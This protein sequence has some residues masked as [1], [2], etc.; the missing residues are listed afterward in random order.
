MQSRLDC[1]SASTEF[2]VQSFEI[3][4]IGHGI[5]ETETI[6]IG[7]ITFTG[8]TEP[9]MVP[10]N[11]ILAGYFWDKCCNGSGSQPFIFLTVSGALRYQLKNLDEMT[12]DAL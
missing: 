7:K 3:G 5:L 2:L 8:L 12:K 10:C 11:Q 1:D 9:Q 4:L 6:D